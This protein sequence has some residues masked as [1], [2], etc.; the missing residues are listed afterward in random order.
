MI[1][2][3]SC[4]ALCILFATGCNNKGKS[5][6]H[7]IQIEQGSVLLKGPN[8][9]WTATIVT[10]LEEVHF[11]IVAYNKSG[12]S[13]NSSGGSE[14]SSNVIYIGESKKKMAIDSNGN[15]TYLP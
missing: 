2:N 7:E 15:V 6:V 1:T 10:G 3:L 4:I 14:G 11:T 5:G 12:C 8:N 13:F 9:E